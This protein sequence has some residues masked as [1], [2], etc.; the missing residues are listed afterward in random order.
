M[1]LLLDALNE[2]PA[3]S[4]REL[5]SGWGVEG[6][7][8]GDRG[9][10]PGQPRGLQLP[11]AGLLARR[12]RRRRC[13][14][15]RCRSSRWR[16][17]RSRR[18]CGLYSP[19]RGRGDLGGA[20]R[21]AAARRAAV[22]VLPGAAGRPGGGDGRAGAATGR[23][24]SPASCGRRCG[25]RWS[26]TTRCS[27]PDGAPRRA[28]TCRRIAQWQWRDAVRAAGA[29]G[30]GAAAGG[31]GVRDAG[32]READGGASQVRVDYDTALEL[33]DHAA[34]RGRS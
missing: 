25:G 6:L 18:S 33:V 32:R 31:A 23:G 16:T 3:A 5:A 21:D 15:R 26:G 24:C 30:A 7:R 28:A 17:S 20:R 12:S 10:C 22:A 11:H 8:A 29:G 19:V 14:C 27:R 1:I 4:E 34:G 2:M 9:D 13:G